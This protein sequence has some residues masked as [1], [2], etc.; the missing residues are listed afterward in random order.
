MAQINTEQLKGR[1]SQFKD[2]FKDQIKTRRDQLKSQLDS[3]SPGA[4]GRLTKTIEEQ[5]SKIPSGGF[6]GLAVGAMILSAALASNKKR[7]DVANF[8]G[9]WVPSLLMIGVYNK[10]VKIHG[11]ER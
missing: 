10:L 5:T 1:A 11:S 4:E 6:L 7:R 8:I 3:F 2:Q 9:L